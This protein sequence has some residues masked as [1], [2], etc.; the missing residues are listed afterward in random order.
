[1]GVTSLLKS[2]RPFPG[3]GGLSGVSVADCPL[4]VRTTDTAMAHDLIDKVRI[5]T[6]LLSRRQDL[7]T[8]KDVG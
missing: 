5:F 6:E 4:K 2:L 7:S 8:W 3:G 1:M